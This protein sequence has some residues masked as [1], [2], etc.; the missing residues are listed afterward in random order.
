MVLLDELDK[1]NEGYRVGRGIQAL[2]LGMLEPETARRHTDVFLKTECDFS[3]VMW[4]ATVNALSTISAPLLS[5]MRVLILRQPGREHLE[6][7]AENVLAE[8]SRQ[9]G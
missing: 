6:V 3:A 9:W 1:A 2:L 8:I 7:I 4:I 5:R